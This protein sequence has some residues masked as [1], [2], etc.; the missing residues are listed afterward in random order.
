MF[1][2]P[3]LVWCGTVG[4]GSRFHN[5]R[6]WTLFGRQVSFSCFAFPNSFS[7]LLIALGL[8]FNVLCSRTHFRPYRGVMSRFHVLRF[9]T[10]FRRYRWRRVPLLCFAPPVRPFSRASH[11]RWV[12]GDEMRKK[13]TKIPPERAFV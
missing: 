9:R 5:L 6:S 2:A 4:V 13:D 1:C 10:H 3:K 7:A 11:R 8:S 12:L